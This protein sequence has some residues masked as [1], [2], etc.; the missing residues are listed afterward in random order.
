MNDESLCQLDGLELSRTLHRRDA[1][2]RDVMQAYLGRIARLNPRVNAIVGMRPE[3]E[4]LAEADRCDAELARGESRGWMHGFP[5]AV[6]DLETTA[7][8]ATTWGSTIFKDNIPSADGLLTSRLKGAGAIIIGKTN[9]PE[10][11]FGSQTYNPVYGVT[12][13]PYDLQR[14]CGGSSGGAAVALALR[15]LPVADGSDMGG[16]LR[17]PAGWCN[18]YGFRPSQGR[19]PKWPSEEVFFAQLPTEGPMARNLPDLTALLATLAGPDPH[20]PLSL[21]HDPGIA[22]GQLSRKSWRGTRI[23]WLG[24]FG[25]HLPMEAGVLDVCGD[26]LK[27]LVG[28]GCEVEATPLGFD[29]ESIW[30]S[31]NVLRS[32]PITA[33]F[34][35]YRNDPSKWSQLKPEAQ[36]EYEQGTKLTGPQVQRAVM[37]RSAWFQHVLKLFERFDYLA[38][39]SAQC[40][41]FD[42]SQHWPAE[43][44]GRKMDTYHRWMEVMAPVT[45]AGVPAIS[46]PA[47]FDTRGL[48]IGLQLFGPPRNDM[49]V[50][51]LAHAYDDATGWVRRYPPAE[52]GSVVA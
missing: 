32:L 16:S 18:V 11:G 35:P 10:W 44:A 38:L 4:L 51:Q 5:H 24:D 15:L 12:R 48:P 21:P 43:L 13:N 17:N 3:A 50:L 28:I 19:V 25:G 31:F 29:A 9:V 39:P 1:S 40:F 49:A 7:G 36:W 20:Q 46:V 33:R 45:L 8:V 2:C 41:P 23:G 52:P 27:A 14:T 37:A 22:P 34:D 47:G 30:Q 26:A 6:K 42:L